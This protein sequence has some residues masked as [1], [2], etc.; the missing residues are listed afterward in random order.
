M[1]LL[2]GVEHWRN[3]DSASDKAVALSAFNVKAVAERIEHVHILT[4]FHLRH[5]AR[6]LA[7][8]LIDQTKHAV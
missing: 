7:L 1:T 8:D 4:C 2:C 5:C 6:P 3:A